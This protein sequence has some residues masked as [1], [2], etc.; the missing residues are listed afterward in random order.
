MFDGF[1]FLIPN[2]LHYYVCMGLGYRTHPVDDMIFPLSTQESQGL[3][4]DRHYT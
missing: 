1:S 4:A 3:G 2:Y